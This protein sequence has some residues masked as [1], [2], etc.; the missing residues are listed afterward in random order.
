[1]LKKWLLPHGT[2]RP[3]WYLAALGLLFSSVVA[4]R[5]RGE[6][7]GLPILKESSIM[8]VKKVVVASWDSPSTLVFGR[9][10]FIIFI[11]CRS[12]GSWRI[13]RSSDLKGIF[14]YGC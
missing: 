6:L 10:W 2:H 1:M 3:H 13:G 4:R 9:S 8:D 5:V 12:S 14:N 11:G 7:D